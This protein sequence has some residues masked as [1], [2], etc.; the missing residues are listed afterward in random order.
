MT[1]MNEKIKKRKDIPDSKK[2]RGQMK[3]ILVDDDPRALIHL[4][5]LLDEFRS[6]QVVG[7]YTNPQ[8]AFKVILEERPDI[9]FLEV[10]MPEVNGLQLTERIRNFHPDLNIVFVT[11]HSKYAAKA[12]EVNAVDYIIKPIKRKRL[13]ET[14]RKVMAKPLSIEKKADTSIVLCCFKSLCFKKTMD[15]SKVIDVNWRTSKARELFSFLLHYRQTPVRKS[16]LTDLFWPAFDEDKG[17]AQLYIAIY[18][19]RKTLEN[20]KV[21]ITISNF[22]NSYVL[23]L[24]DTKLDVDVWEE[25]INALSTVNEKNL[26][27]TQELLHLYTGDYLSEEGYIWAENERERLRIQWLKYIRKIADF[28]ISKERYMEAILLYQR[29]QILYPYT[30]N[31]YF[32]LMK[33]YDRIGNEQSLQ[34]QY[35]KLRNMLRKEYDVKPNKVI[36][37]WYEDWI[38]R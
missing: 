32:M 25:K 30:D 20:L 6:F 35:H 19:I 12:F 17:R 34:Q 18:Q 31:S 10:V 14:I 1:I 2:V 29:V 8:K 38:K 5:Q 11:A 23:D 37:K 21:K 3:A 4:A 15:D 27:Q 24:H 28:Y 26:P 13:Q 9:V 22:E 33:L 36:E 7:Q 16:I